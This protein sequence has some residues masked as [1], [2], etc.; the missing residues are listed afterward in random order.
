MSS[1]SA[2][3]SLL[4]TQ[5]ACHSW[6]SSGQIVAGREANPSAWSVQLKRPDR[7]ATSQRT[8]SPTNVW[9]SISFSVIFVSAKAT[10]SWRGFFGLHVASTMALLARCSEGVE[11][12]VKSSNEIG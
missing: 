1:S 9:L 4:R 2:E 12:T 10:G 5:A 6:T 7:S 11:A 3:G 8:R